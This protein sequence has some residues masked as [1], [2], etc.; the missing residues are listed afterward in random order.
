MVLKK[1]KI[2]DE[3]TNDEYEIIMEEKQYYKFITN[4]MSH[5]FSKGFGEEV[6]VTSK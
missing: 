2:I 1:Y 5:M 4:L 3:L 6:E